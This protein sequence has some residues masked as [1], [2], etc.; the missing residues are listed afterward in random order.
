MSNN[1]A[2]TKRIR[3]LFQETAST[4]VKKQDK[5]E[6]E[7]E[8][9]HLH[10]KAEKGWNRGTNAA[11]AN[12]VNNQS[13][14]VPKTNKPAGPSS[15][16]STQ[17]T[18]HGSN[19][20][21]RSHIDRTSRNNYHSRIQ[22]NSTMRKRVSQKSVHKDEEEDLE[23]DH[24]PGGQ[25]NVNTSLQEKQRKRLE[26]QNRFKLKPLDPEKDF[27]ADGTEK[28]CVRTRLMLKILNMKQKKEDV[29]SE[30]HMR[31][32]FDE[33]VSDVS[34]DD[35]DDEL[36]EEEV[37]ARKARKKAKARNK[38]AKKIN[39]LKILQM[40]NMFS[41]SPPKRAR[42]PIMNVY[43]TD[44]DV[45]KKAAKQFCG[46]RIKEYKEDHEGGI[47]KGQTQ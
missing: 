12:A 23:S 11:A 41:K 46:F 42:K 4:K 13:L 19:M 31:N 26:A 29:H 43:C 17:I 14:L 2:S 22:Y 21:V 10:S 15:I 47:I 37:K 24:P 28:F 38:K 25:G 3:T 9:K 35:E 44:Y 6:K 36:D 32:S 33:E 5:F 30:D 45:V 18:H 16:A 7:E 1:R 27:N 40:N 8:E 39:M 34:Y 20:N